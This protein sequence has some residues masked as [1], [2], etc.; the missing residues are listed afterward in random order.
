M[1]SGDFWY[2]SKNSSQLKWFQET[3]KR[4]TPETMS[5][6]MAE[7]KSGFYKVNKWQ[8]IIILILSM[9]F[10]CF[11]KPSHF[12]HLDGQ[13]E[14][15]PAQVLNPRIPWA[16]WAP[17]LPQYFKALWCRWSSWS[18]WCWSYG[19]NL[20][21]NCVIIVVIRLKPHWIH[22]LRGNSSWPGPTKI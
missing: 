7:I 13:A 22:R 4:L 21:F 12:L 14:S 5:G 20:Y 11:K 16:Q 3:V 15:D 9:L 18:W 19:F 1:I 6:V 2:K 8:K 17:C 10:L